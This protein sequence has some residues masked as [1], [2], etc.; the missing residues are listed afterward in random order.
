[1]RSTDLDTDGDTLALLDAEATNLGVSDDRVRNF[2][3]L[4]ELDD[5]LREGKLLLARLARRLAE[6]RRELK[7]LA[8]A[9]GEP[10]VSRTVPQGDT[11]GRGTHVESGS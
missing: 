7:A 2:L 6:E 1:M 9:A 10:L 8:N 5:L 4:E 3:Q 11:S